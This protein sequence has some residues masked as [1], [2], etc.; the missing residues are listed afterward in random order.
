MKINIR[1]EKKK[2]SIFNKIVLGSFLLA[3]LFSSASFES[4]DSECRVQAKEA[5]LNAYQGCVKEA[6]SQKI[7]DIRKEYQSK[8]N[9]LKNYYDTELKKL[10]PSKDEKTRTDNFT[11]TEE[12]Q[13]AEIPTEASM[14]IEIKKKPKKIKK[15]NSKNG[16]S[17]SKTSALPTKKIASKTLP[18]QKELP[19][20]EVK[21][22]NSSI[23]ETTDISSEEKTIETNPN[24]S[25]IDSGNIE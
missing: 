13:T 12:P 4:I 22:T 7:D 3:P 25:N 15:T 2:N 19:I 6:R 14:Q 9:E 10:T 24:I 20:K 16:V 18:A 1:S 23:D 11:S 5:A 21:N 17:N 8:L